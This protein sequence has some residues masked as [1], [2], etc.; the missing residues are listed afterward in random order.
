MAISSTA[1]RTIYIVAALLT[2][3]SLAWKVIAVGAWRLSHENSFSVGEKSVRVPFPWIL[4]RNRPAKM[5]AFTSLWPT[6][7]DESTVVIDK[8]PVSQ[9]GES[10]SD[11]LLSREHE[12]GSVGFSNIRRESVDGGRVICAEAFNKSTGL[13]YCRSQANLL[14]IYAG[15]IGLARS[16]IDL[17][18]S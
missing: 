1:K 6:P 7:S 14:L 9:Q 2:V 13:V 4:V 12:L 11:W 3:A 5:E 18:P 15:P 8:I 17:L 16:S 10:E